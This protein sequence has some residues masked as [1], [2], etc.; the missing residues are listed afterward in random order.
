[1]ASILLGEWR[2]FLKS[3]PLVSLCPKAPEID[4]NEK[5]IKVDEPGLNP[6]ASGVPNVGERGTNCGGSPV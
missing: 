1:M 4:G 5:L 3:L 2:S 6:L